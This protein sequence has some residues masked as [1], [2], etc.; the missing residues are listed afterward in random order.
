LHLS[1]TSTAGLISRVR[2]GSKGDEIKGKFRS[3]R[4]RGWTLA[5]TA[6][7]TMAF[8]VHSSAATHY[9]SQTSPNSTPPYSTP[10]TA[11]HAIQE[12][13]DVAIDGDTVLV[14]PGDYAL[15]NQVTVTNGIRLQ[16]A[17][18]ASQT[19]LTALTNNIWCLK[20][21]N[22]LAVVEGLSLRNQYDPYGGVSGGAFLAGGTIQNCTFSNFYVGTPGGAIVASG[23]MVSNSIVTYRRYGGGIGATAVYGDGVLITDCLVLGIQ[24]SGS[25]GG[26]SLTNSKLQNSVISGVLNSGLAAPGVA[27]AALSSSV[28]NCTISNNLNIATGGG[29]HLEDSLMDRC[30]VTHNTGGG[31][32]SGGGGIFEIN[33]VI[34]DSLITSNSLTFSSGEPGCGS[35]GGGVYMRGGSL[36]NCT[37][38]GN[39]ARVIANGTGGGGGVFAESGG[40]TNCIIYFNLVYVAN[41]P[42]SNWL[43]M[44]SAIFDHCCT[45]PAPGGAANITQ[46][47]QFVDVTSGDFHL[48]STSPCIDAGM[49][50]PW[51]IG[52]Q[53]LDGHQ[54]VGGTSVD[55][56]AYEMSTATPQEM[57]QALVSDVNNLI[58]TGTLTHGHGNALLAG[59][60]AA[61]KSLERGSTRATCGQVGA[62]INK[63]QTFIDKGELSKAD[64]QSLISTAQDLRTALGC[65]SK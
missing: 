3:K 42:A 12:A 64:G 14:E 17:G 58:A 65:G 59:L 20:V 30:I 51:M 50:Q 62:F 36:V 24:S 60:R 52:A 57:V 11:A 32:C 23:G 26:V 37:V 55:I 15:T 22:S 44:G 5:I 7:V 8:A 39:S 48:A 47:P 56:G 46:D 4:T 9:V 27:L 10:D 41:N 35:Y 13:V 40:V 16:G 45:T 34:R 28:V 38:A 19:F 21:T 25:G 33:S 2:P 18:G 63:L 54:R 29:V 1:A 6:A 61:L 49:T 43:S 53:D 31:E